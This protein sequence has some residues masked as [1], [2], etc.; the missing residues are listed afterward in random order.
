MDGV[1]RS[2]AYDRWSG[3]ES[4]QENQPQARQ[5]LAGNLELTKLPSAREGSKWKSRWQ[6]PEKRNVHLIERQQDSS[7]AYN[8]FV[9]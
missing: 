7:M 1:Q 4:G 2:F 6:F 9:A 5:W 8:T 3:F